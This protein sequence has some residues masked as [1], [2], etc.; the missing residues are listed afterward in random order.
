MRKYRN[1]QLNKGYIIGIKSD[2]NKVKNFYHVPFNIGEEGAE[3]FYRNTKQKGYK[4]IPESVD[5]LRA[6]EI[7]LGSRIAALQAYADK[8]RGVKH[9]M[10]MV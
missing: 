10:N 3:T 5:D 8:Y 1:K 2:G 4:R 6:L 7:I 9:P